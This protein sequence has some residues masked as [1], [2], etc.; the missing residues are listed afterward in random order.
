[1]LTITDK[2]LQEIAKIVSDHH[3]ALAMRVLGTTAFDER[4][5][6]RLVRKG[7]VSRDAA[8]NYPRLAYLFGRIVSLLGEEAAKSLTFREFMEY[9]QRHPLP[10]TPLHKASI[11]HGVRRMQHYTKSFGDGVEK[12]IREA[13][14]RA[15]KKIRDIIDEDVL[16][17]IS[18]GAERGE[19]VQEIL[20]SIRNMTG[21]FTRNWLRIVA[22]ETNDILVEG[23]AT[24]I[25]KSSPKRGQERVFKRPRPDACEWCVKHYLMPDRKT[26]RIFTLDELRKAGD[27]H[28][29][30]KAEWKPVLGSMHPLCYCNLNR[31]PDGFGFDEDGNMVYL[32][33]PQL[34]APSK[35]GTIRSADFKV[36]A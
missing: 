12:K 13:V 16:H 8:E 14:I 22:T 30:S 27:N 6:K 19:T 29:L 4:E 32:S 25:A 5:V 18:L 31:L 3:K 28:G 11:K 26:P 23:L 35:P 1:M 2:Q 34:P 7:L 24:E 9:L 15:D 20:R 10:E 17:R 21:D 33:G 36:R